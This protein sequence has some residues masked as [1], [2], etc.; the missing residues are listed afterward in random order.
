MRIGFV[1]NDVQTE[2]AGYTTIRLAMT[3]VNR[4]HEAWLMGAGDLAFDPDGLVRA[5]ARSVT[6]VSYKSTKQFLSDLQGSKAKVERITV[7]HLDVLI[8]R[9]DPAEDRIKRPWAQTA[10]VMF[11][12]PC[13]AKA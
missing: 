13:C 8:L 11:G 5:R 12:R 4:G 2:E 7:D 3:G 6:K 1:V 9:N 10:G